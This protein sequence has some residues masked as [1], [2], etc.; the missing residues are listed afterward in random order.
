MRLIE[1]LLGLSVFPSQHIYPDKYAA[2]PPPHD[3]SGA[4]YILGLRRGHTPHGLRV[5]P[6]P[7]LTPPQQAR[8]RPRRP[9]QRSTFCHC[10]VDSRQTSL[11]NACKD[12]SGLFSTISSNCSTASMYHLFFVSLKHVL[13]FWR[14]LLAAYYVRAP[15][16][17]APFFRRGA[18]V[19]TADKPPKVFFQDSAIPLLMSR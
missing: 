3:F 2:C 4:F 17:F 6:I 19:A 1:G 8:V 14:R 11:Q 7:R 9:G 18:L 10:S 12:T 16:N 13:P 15:L 5:P